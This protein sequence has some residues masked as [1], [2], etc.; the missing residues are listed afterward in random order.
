VITNRLL[1]WVYQTYSYV[2]VI[3]HEKDLCT[4]PVTVSDTVSEVPV[5]T[6]ESFSAYLPVNVDVEK[7]I[8]YSIRLTAD[9]LEAPVEEEAF[10][11]YVAVL[12]GTQV[13]ATLPLYTTAGAERSTFMGAMNDM[14]DFI[15]KRSVLAGMIFFAVTLIA[16]I[17]VEAIAARR[18]KRRWDKY[19]TNKIQLSPD[20]LRRNNRKK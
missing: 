1:D 18:K 7:E 17:T 13:L 20:Q 8:S 15:L 9:A 19:F 11:G 3:S 5:R 14:Q 6:K 4:I 12:Y 16:W 2:E 10:V